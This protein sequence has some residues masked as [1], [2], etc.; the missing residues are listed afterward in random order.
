M[1]FGTYLKR[2]IGNLL[3]RNKWIETSMSEPSEEFLQNFYGSSSTGVNVTANSAL[4]FSAVYAAVKAISEDIAGLQINIVTK[5]A[6]GTKSENYEHNL[7]SLFDEPNAVQTGFSF[8]ETLLAMALLWGNGYAFINRDGFGY[9][10]GMTFIHSSNVTPYIDSKGYVWYQVAGIK[11]AVP[12]YHMIHLA[13]LGFNG[14]SGKSVIGYAKENI[15]LGLSA[16]TFGSLMFSQGLNPGIMIEYPNKMEEKKYL[17]I[18]DSINEMYGGLGNSHKALI[19]DGGAK[20]SKL[21]MP[22]KDAQFMELRQFQLEEIARWFRIPQHMIGNLAN[23]TNNN[24]EAQG[25]EYVKYTLL[26]WVKRLEA[27]YNR[28]LVP[29][30]ENGKTRI[31]FNLDTLLRADTKTRS[32]FYN[33]MFNI[34]A[35]SPNEIRKIENLNPRPG[36]DEYFTPMNM[37]GSVAGKL[38]KRTMQLFSDMLNLIND[39]TNGTES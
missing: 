20:A 6:D 24:I 23:S 18:K 22:S 26:P 25:I 36:G 35:L 9:A 31:K 28:K 34:G 33:V 21:S 30:S 3:V 32:E 12:A 13:G 29:V 19:L 38:P 7:N 27:E 14:Y 15:S 8:T 1:K 10:V 39:N 37:Q 4:K 11:D 2:E 17:L 5:N 16:E